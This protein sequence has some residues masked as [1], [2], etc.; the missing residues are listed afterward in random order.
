MNQKI[1]IIKDTKT[2]N[3]YVN[4]WLTSSFITVDTE[5]IRDK[6][7]WPKLCLIQI[8]GEQESVIIDP[9]S[10]DIDLESLLKLLN[11]TTVLKVFHAARQDLEVFYHLNGKIPSPIFDTQVAASV[12]GFG[13]AAGYEKLVNK[14]VGEKIDKTLRFTDWSQR[15]LSDKQLSYALSDVSHLRII[16]EKLRKKLSDTGR[17]SWIKEDMN[18]L[19]NINNYDINPLQVWRK[20]KTRG[21]SNRFY[22]I[23]REI[24]SWREI[25]ARK[26]NIPRG[27][28]LKDEA[29]NEIAAIA[30]SSVSELSKVRS[31]KNRKGDIQ[32]GDAIINCVKVA[33]E[34]PKNSWPTPPEKKETYRGVGPMMDL[35]KVLLKTQ[36][37]TAEVAQRIV[38]N[39]YDLQRIA[40]MPVKALE[41]RSD[42]IAALKGWRRE[43]FG[44]LALALKAGRLAFTIENENIK[45][46][47]INEI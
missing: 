34:S 37:E 18:T 3:S 31:L 7:Y 14:L 8:G 17:E 29:I 41:A 35:L 9:L 27:R 16:Y 26:K 13:D 11:D 45:I 40:A 10:K 25:E 15:P 2:L 19:L 5:F 6:T 1:K 32:W 22:V 23:L 4:G 36:C 33:I 30:P 43:I 47:R 39:N 44:E 38:A 12:C 20:I 24:A 28:I 42:E 21:G 46:L